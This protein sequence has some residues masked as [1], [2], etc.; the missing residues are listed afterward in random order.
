VAKKILILCNDFPPINSV[1]ADRPYSWYK[2]FKEFNLEPIV[3]TKNWLTDGHTPFNE[4]SVERSEEKTEFGTI[5][6]AARTITPSSWFRSIFGQRLSV[7][8]KALTL[9]EK[10]MSF[11]VFSF[12]QN[13]TIYK[14]A[15][16]F[17]SKNQVSL[18]IT[19]GE[20]FVLFKY[21]FLLKKKYNIPWIADYR[22]GWYLNHVRSIQTDFF[23]KLI[24]AKELKFELKFTQLADLITTVDPELA[25][26]IASLTSK[27]T[28]VVYNGFWDFHQS[29]TEQDEKPK[30]VLNHTGT[31][32]IGQRLELLL[33][34]LVELKNEHQIDERQVRL[35]LVGL[36]YF[37]A[38]MERLNKYRNVLG[39]IIQTTPRLTKEDA[40]R[41]N[42]EADY[43]VNFTDPNLSAIYAKTYDYIASKK[44]ILVIPGDGKLLER[45]VLDNNLGFVLSTKEEIK[46]FLLNPIIWNPSFSGISFFTRKKQAEQLSLKIKNILGNLHNES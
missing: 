12:D 29:I 8:R 23:N 26:R 14:E 15:C 33:D 21:G 3:I 5:I 36:E 45:L 16:Q 28:E 9:I 6:R 44:P 41:M 35:N 27:K 10:L 42:L 18:I 17:I 19:T 39:K 22:D 30:I 31:L 1:G 32:T 7:I 4:V 43:L 37:S 24:R 20:P 2:Y 11:S 13:S 40:V 25:S 38:Q 46:S 34:A